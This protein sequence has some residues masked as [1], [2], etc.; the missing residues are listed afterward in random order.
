MLGPYCAKKHHQSLHVLIL[1][2]SWP[3]L[4]VKAFYVLIFSLDKRV[5]NIGFMCVWKIECTLDNKPYRTLQPYQRTFLSK[6]LQNHKTPVFLSWPYKTLQKNFSGISLINNA[7]TC[8]FLQKICLRCAEK[9]NFCILMGDRQVLRQ[10]FCFH[11]RK[12]MNLLR[13]SP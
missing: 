2:L 9:F 8:H 3:K 6:T 12:F 10:K 13:K 4:T 7:I 1:I 11:L 5:E